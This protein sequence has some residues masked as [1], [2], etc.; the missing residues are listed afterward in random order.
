MDQETTAIIKRI[1]DATNKV[2]TKLQALID[3]AN[4]AGTVTAAEIR[5]ALEPEV[6]RLEG[7]GADPA[8][9]VPALGVQG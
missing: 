4:S 9:P 5:A 3:K 1:D 6:Q 7:L 8:N 2:A